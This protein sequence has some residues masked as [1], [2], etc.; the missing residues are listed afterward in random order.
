[1]RRGWRHISLA[2]KVS[3]LF[4]AAVLLTIA[5]TLLFPWQQMTALQEQLMLLRAKR[6]ATAV[7]LAVD[8]TL[9]DWTLVQSD[10]EARWSSLVAE[11]DLPGECPRLVP[12]GS[13]GPGFHAEA[14]DRLTDVPRQRYYWRLQDEG[15][16]FRLAM[17]VRR[18]ITDAH[19]RVLRGLI[20]V[21]LPLEFSVGAWNW[22]VTV[23]AGASGAM[24]AMFTFYV[25]TQR[26]V[27]GPVRSLKDVAERV[28]SGDMQTK[29]MLRRGDEFGELSE[30]IN[31]MLSHIKAAQEEQQRVNRSLDVKLGELA[32]T[33]VALF[34][35][36]RVKG[37]FLANVTHELRTPLV[38]I[39]G[40]A[41]LVRDYCEATEIDRRKLTRYAQN[42]VTSG[43]SLLELINDLL[44]LAKL[45]A[46]KIELHLSEFSIE[47]LCRDLMDFMRP[48]ADKQNQ[49]LTL[50]VEEG[51]PP[52]HSDAG[53]LKQVLYNL[54]SNAVKF[55]P[56]GGAVALRVVTDGEELV[57]MAVADTGPGIA[58]EHLEH[59]FEKFRQL[60]AS[61]TREH[62]GTGLGLAITRELVTMLGGSI[63]VRSEVGR[64]SE[65]TVRLPCR[66]EPVV[67]RPP[68]RLN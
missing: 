53:R 14:I 12:V 64:G 26:Q 58:P 19:S 10:L 66:A 43:R 24:L 15:R 56:T 42:I 21:V 29:S 68:I 11:F 34:E 46:S 55:T 5:V 38:S 61:H 7:S 32:E 28:T 54:L 51:L 6:V 60:D 16:S 22:M 20:D 47:Q 41:E 8:L 25:V 30:A 39:I 9:P 50:D 49:T 45:E 37:E 17:A 23:L 1:M 35:A 48:V 4:G 62:A 3:L 2:R 40:F 33:N 13:H 31:D 57:R 59:I 18:P 63:E 36:S 67:D 44:D 65:F 52:F 27:L